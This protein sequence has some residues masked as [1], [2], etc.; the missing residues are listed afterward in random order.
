LKELAER[1]GPVS[2]DHET[3]EHGEGHARSQRKAERGSR[4]D[5]G[6][7][8]GVSGSFEAGG[9]RGDQRFPSNR[10]RCPCAWPQLAA[11]LSTEGGN[12]RR[13]EQSWKLCRCDGWILV[14]AAS[15]IVVADDDSAECG[16]RLANL[17]L[18]EQ[19]FL[20]LASVV[21]PCETGRVSRTNTG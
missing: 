4:T 9:N 18:G 13:P 19:S 3:R 20:W 1:R 11:A 12:A 17:A 8:G 16:G 5:R 21:D 6:T 7:A 2:V 15:D 10:G 14:H